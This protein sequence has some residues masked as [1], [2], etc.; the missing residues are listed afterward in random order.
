[1]SKKKICVT[2]SGR[3]HEIAYIAL[4][5]HPAEPQGR[6]VARMVRLDQVIEGYEGPMVNLD[7]DAAGVLIGIEVLA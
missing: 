1:M 5:G 3:N 2:L 4:P 7:F 6:V